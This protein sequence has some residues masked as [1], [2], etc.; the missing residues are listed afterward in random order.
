MQLGPVCYLSTYPELDML[1][2]GEESLQW[3]YQQRQRGIGQS[4]DSTR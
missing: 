2:C 1:L 4:M 3:L